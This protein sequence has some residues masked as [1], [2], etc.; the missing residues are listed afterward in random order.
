MRILTMKL[1]SIDSNS[2]LAKT[3]AK[4]GA[5]HLYA[6]LSMMPDRTL[7]PGSKAAGCMDACLKSA[8]RGRFSNV[9]LAR[10]AKTDWFHADRQGFVQTLVKDLEA[11]VRKANR[12]GKTAR[13]RLNVLSDV[14]WESVPCERHGEA[15][16]GIPEAFPEIEFYDYTKRAARLGKTQAN[17]HLTFSYSGVRT[18]IKQVVQAREANANMAVVF[19]VKKGQPLPRLWDGKI[20]IDGDEHDAR[21]DD[22][23]NVIIGLRAKGQAIKDKSGF[24]VPVHVH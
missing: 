11:L 1:L 18:Y 10:Q 9:A 12:E 7:C 4:V 13:V 8:G 23:A 22:P 21:S 24:V 2:K 5:G 16:K 17:Y 19:H 20:V 14:S 15:F 6:G 3:N